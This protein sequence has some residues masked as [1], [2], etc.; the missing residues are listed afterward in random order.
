MRLLADRRRRDERIAGGGM[1]KLAT[2]VASACDRMVGLALEELAVGGGITKA[3]WGGDRAGRGPVDRGRQGIK[4]SSL[5]EG[6]GIPLGTVVGPAAPATT[7]LDPT[8]RSPEPVWPVPRAP[9]VHLDRDD[10][11]PGTP[12]QSVPDGLIAEISPK[13]KLAPV[14][15]TGRWVVER[16]YAWTNAH[17][18]LVWCT[19]RRGRVIRFWLTF[20]AGFITV[21]RLLREGWTRSGWDNRPRRKP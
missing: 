4:R 18:E 20:A 3:P 12:S 1:A 6:A 13:G 14:A 11:F 8:P 2:V 7:L 21:G 10:D 16:T 5:V 9:T 19:D 15:A 17:K